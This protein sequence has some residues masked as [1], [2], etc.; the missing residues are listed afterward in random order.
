MK[1]FVSGGTGFVGRHVVDAIKGEGHTPRLLARKGSEKKLPDT[2]GLEFA[3]VDIFDT[4]GVAKEMSGCDAAVHLVG[5]IREFPSKGITFEKLHYR[6]TA[7]MVDAAKSAGLKRF[8]HM[9]ALGASPDSASEYHTTKHRALTYVADSGL[10]Y[11]IFSPSLIFGPED[12]SIN[13]FLDM[14]GRA[15]VVPV[16]GNGEYP[17]APV[18]IRSVAQGFARALTNEAAT[19]K[20]F[21][22]GGPEVFTYNELLD[23]LG[24]FL[25]KEKVRKIHMPVFIMRFFAWL[26]SWL[27]SFP[28]TNPQITMLLE[29]RP[30]DSAEFY[31]ILGVEPVRLVDGLK[32]YYGKD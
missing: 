8:L 15:P 4:E 16:I 11:A 28:V 2:D 31:D 5:I 14:V 9:A 19:G 12:L 7:S 3:H 32:E 30:P 24:S 13:T 6:A 27:P 1:V 10:D 18:S 26:F 29:G 20:H 17:L 25:G 23:T 21:E 22:V